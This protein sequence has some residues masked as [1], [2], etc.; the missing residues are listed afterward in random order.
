MATSL[1]KIGAL[2][3]GETIETARQAEALQALQV[4]LRGW[5]SQ[6]INIFVATKEDITL[7][8]G[9][10]SYTWGSGGDIATTRPNQV[11][12]AYLL[13]GSTTSRIEIIDEG[14]YRRI[15]DKTVSGTPS[16]LL[17]RPSYPLGQIF[18]FPVP[19]SAFTL[20]SYSYKEFTETGSFA[21]TTDT[22]ALPAVYQEA[23]IYN[24]A[25]RL[26]PEYGKT[27]SSD[28]R[29]VAETSFMDLVNL[30]AANQIETVTL[31]LPIGFKYTD[32]AINVR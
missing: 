2:S 12:S 21:L 10:G 9:V 28:V 15:T 1:R 13:S 26:A 4:M 19:S 8:G 32:Y 18:L 30:N 11:I 22:M 6:S 5:S 24:L 23:V 20:V 27:A 29:S 14:K 17:Y 16:L 25:L 7:I 31:G 3:S